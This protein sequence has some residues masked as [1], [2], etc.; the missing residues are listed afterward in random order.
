MPPT[1]Y[2]RV[3]R[4]AFAAQAHIRTRPT[5]GLDEDG[6]SRVGKHPHSSA[7]RGLDGSSGTVSGDL[8]ASAAGGNWRP[9]MI[10]YRMK[11]GA[12]AILR[13]P[14]VFLRNLPSRLVLL[15]ARIL[16]K[17]VP[18]LFSVEHDRLYPPE[19][20]SFAEDWVATDKTGLSEIRHVD[21]ACTI[22]LKPP[23]TVHHCIRQQ[24]LTTLE[25]VSG[26]RRS[27]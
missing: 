20:I 4:N 6:Q 19:S 12:K 2:D 17:M 24:F 13:R 22:Q 26:H 14:W 25:T 16:T 10:A 8:S 1:A 11:N 7:S 5:E 23:K 21:P 15:G 18:R 9:E 3:R 27:S